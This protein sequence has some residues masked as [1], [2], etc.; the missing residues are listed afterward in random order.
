M[1]SRSFVR[2]FARIVT[3]VIFGLLIRGLRPSPVMAQGPAREPQQALPYLSPPPALQTQD[4]TVVVNQAT[5]EQILA[6]LATAEAEIQALRQQP[7]GAS[8]VETLPPPTPPAT[9]VA[10]PACGDATK[11]ADVHATSAKYLIPLSTD[12]GN[13][14]FKPG[15][16]IQPRYVLDN[17]NNNND[18]FL[19]RFRLKSSGE[20]FDFAKY[21]TELKFDGDG[22]FET[23][24]EG[25]VENAW[26]DFTVW[27]E[28]TYFRVG[29]YDVPFSRDALTSDSKLLFMD[30]SLVKSALTELG[31]ADNGIGLMFHGR[32]DCGRFEYAVGIFDSVE[33]EDDGDDGNGPTRDS[34]ELMPI[35]R[36]VWHLLDPATPPDGYADYY[37][38][39]LGQGQRL[40]IGANAAYLQEASIDDD[41]FSVYAWGV[42]LFFN[43]GPYTLQAEYDWFM[44]DS[45]GGIPDVRGDGWY[46]QAGYF[47]NCCWELAGRYQLLD[48]DHDVFGDQLRWTSVGLNYY[49]WKHNLK[50]QTDYTFKDEQGA[51]VADNVLQV[52]LQLDY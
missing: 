38:S 6:R 17:S 13:I 19:A 31:F 44:Q 3:L 27:P 7:V 12:C 45:V 2:E 43:R 52:Q 22:K 24:V 42:D 10:A 1:A 9:F 51:D 49:I 16:R 48:P 25:E 8:G 32:P 20:I 33:F 35:G 5:L 34:D 28:Q 40:D 15:L 30:R 26:L 11:Y 46:V 50:I 4:G 37:G 18:F 41:E 14:T 23:L 36:V 47:F 21:G 29:L 39:Y